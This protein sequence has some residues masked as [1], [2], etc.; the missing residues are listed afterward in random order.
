MRA[1]ACVCAS[2]ISVLM[3]SFNLEMR[4]LGSCL[5]IYQLSS[6]R[7]FAATDMKGWTAL[8]YCALKDQVQLL[9]RDRSVG[10]YIVLCT[11]FSMNMCSF[12]LF[13]KLSLATSI[14]AIY[15]RFVCL[16][17]LSASTCPQAHL[18]MHVNMCIPV[19]HLPHAR[20]PSMH[21]KK[22]LGG[23]WSRASMP[24]NWTIKARLRYKLRRR[25]TRRLRYC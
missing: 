16:T 24:Q 9:M 7:P 23:S 6:P 10:W 11:L 21:R 15:D 5:R 22:L 2:R 25:M 12:V 3:H 20:M 4:S 19:A 18:H 17:F 8:H 14:P 13:F 1:R